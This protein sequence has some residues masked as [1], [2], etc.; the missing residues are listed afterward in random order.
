MMYLLP[1]TK[2]VYIQV[3]LNA[4]CAQHVLLSIRAYQVL[5]V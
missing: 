4:A 1:V 5:V 3:Q 2:E